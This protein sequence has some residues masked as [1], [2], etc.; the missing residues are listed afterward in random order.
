MNA[1]RRPVAL[2]LSSQLASRDNKLGQV[3]GPLHTLSVPPYGS[4]VKFL[5]RTTPSNRQKRGVEHAKGCE[6]VCATNFGKGQERRQR[7][8][9]DFGQDFDLFVPLMSRMPGHHWTVPSGR[10]RGGKFPI[11]PVT[12]NRG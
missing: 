6:H 4:V 2:A 8:L 12:K 9:E 11:A 5:H 7:D 3:H 1:D 10:G